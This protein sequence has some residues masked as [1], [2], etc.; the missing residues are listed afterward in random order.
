MVKQHFTFSNLP[1]FRLAIVKDNDRSQTFPLPI[2]MILYPFQQIQQ[3]FLDLLGILQ[4][5][6]QNMILD[7]FGCSLAIP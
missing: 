3:N 1:L 6:I 2:T 5:M 7:D 4:H